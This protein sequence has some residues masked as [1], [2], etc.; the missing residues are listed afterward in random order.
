V[1]THEQAGGQIKMSKLYSLLNSGSVLS[2]FLQVIP[3]TLLAGVIYAVYRCVR[4]KKHGNTV[5]WGTEIMCWLFVCYLTGLVNLI[6]VPANLWMYI[7]ANIFVGYS[8]S[9][10]AFFSGEF[11]LVPIFFKWIAGELTVGRWVLKMLIYNF[12]MFVPFGFFL[13]FVS[14]K[15][16]YRSI[17]KIVVIIPI[18]V[19]VIQPVVGRSFDV[20]DLFL[21]FAGIIVGYF[22]AFGIRQSTGAFYGGRATIK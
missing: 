11:N 1:N 8:H 17:W 16:N 10:I 12:L 21:N 22:V 7:W 15:I 2:L 19:E 18:A 6:L 14:K 5:N 4:I 13:P 3:I 20:D 9:E